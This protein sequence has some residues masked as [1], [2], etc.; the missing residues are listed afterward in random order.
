[1]SLSAFLSVISFW[2]LIEVLCAIGRKRRGGFGRF[3]SGGLCGL[4]RA[5]ARSTCTRL[6]IRPTGSADSRG[7]QGLSTRRGRERATPTDRV[8]AVG[9][10]LS[11]AARA[12]RSCG[13]GG[14]HS[15][16]SLRMK[17]V[18]LIH[19]EKAWMKRLWIPVVGSIRTPPRASGSQPTLSRGSRSTC[20]RWGRR[21]DRCGKREHS[22]ERLSACRF[23][24]S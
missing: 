9:D 12:V 14:T 19:R 24:D 2:P 15:C 3:Q 10:R 7:G 17:V 23:G 18:R 4:G 1:M 8:G 16:R 13:I 22:P 20:K 11:A 5:P 6:S 21:V